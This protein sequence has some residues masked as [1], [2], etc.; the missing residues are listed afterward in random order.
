MILAAIIAALTAVVAQV[1]LLLPITVVPVTLQVLMVYL[2]GA[3][4]GPVWGAISMLLYLLLGAIGLP[5]FAGGAGG[6]NVLVGLTGGYLVSYPVAAYLIGLLAPP[7]RT[8]P[9]WRIAAAMLAGLVVVYI[10][11]GLWAMVLGKGL[12]VV[13]TAFVLPFL[14]LDLAKLLVAAVLAAAVRRALASQGY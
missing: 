11:G 9:F 10:G 13:V 1:K 5:V 8:Q 6:L 2:A 12:A 7:G 3:L 4:L 14:P